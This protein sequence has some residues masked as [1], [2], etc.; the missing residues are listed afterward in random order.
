MPETPK[1]PDKS[2]A[3]ADSSKE[4]ITDLPKK[5]IPEQNAETGKGGV[6]NKLR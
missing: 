2:T 1:N 4:K 5:P 6:V 3:D